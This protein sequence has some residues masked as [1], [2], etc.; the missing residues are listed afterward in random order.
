MKTLLYKIRL[1]GIFSLI[2]LSLSC[3]KEE[4]SP[5]EKFVGI[6]DFYYSGPVTDGENNFLKGQG[7]LAVISPVKI[8][9]Y[10]QLP[11]TPERKW[12]FSE[13]EIEAIDPKTDVYNNY[14]KIIDKRDG[15]EI[16]R[17]RNWDYY[18]YSI[19][20]KSYRIM[21][22]M[23][24]TDDKNEKIVLYAIKRKD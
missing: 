7:I 9:I 14:A 13:I 24:F 12:E 21:L 8:I 2:I 1:Y 19:K 20:A 10:E 23:N 18:D 22:V 16:G 6:H 11:F 5:N 15:K 17:I 3:K 4:V